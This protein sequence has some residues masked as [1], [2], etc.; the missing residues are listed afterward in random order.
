MDHLMIVF[1]AIKEQSKEA[2]VTGRNVIEIEK[3]AINTQLFIPLYL[4]LEALQG[5]GLIKFC[6]RTKEIILTEKGRCT[7]AYSL[8][9][10]RFATLLFL[11]FIR[12][13]VLFALFWLMLLMVEKQSAATGRDLKK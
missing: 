1:R 10:L 13:V 9:S 7:D 4:Q 8:F 11:F 3:S 6:P 12:R 2:G 5:V